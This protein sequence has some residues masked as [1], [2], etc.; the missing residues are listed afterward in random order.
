MLSVS[1][2]D[3][4]QDLNLCALL[5]NGLQVH[6]DAYLI[7]HSVIIKIIKEIMCNIK[8]ASLLV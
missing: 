8:I 3:A 1:K 4:Y 5:L 7:D 6:M 2:K